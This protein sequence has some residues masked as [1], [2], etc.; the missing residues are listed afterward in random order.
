MQAILATAKKDNPT[1]LTVVFFIV[2][3]LWWLTIYLSGTTDSSVNH[4]FGFIYG[5]FSIWG[6]YWGLKISKEWGGTRSLMGR[7]I[8]GLA[9]GLLFQAFGQY[10]FWFY[11]YILRISVPYPSISDV[12]FFGTIPFYIYAAFLFTKASGGKISLR[13]V[14]KQV[15]AIVIPIIM[16]SISYFLFLRNYSFDSFE[17]LKTFFDFGYPMGQAIYISIAILNYSLCRELLGGIMRNKIILLIIA[18]FAQ[19]LAD[20]IFI[21]FHDLYF[22]ASF[23]DYMYLVAYFLMTLALLQIKT[24]ANRFREGKN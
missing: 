23:I 15:H 19:Y 22:P 7:A 14:A 6:G 17:P 12:G 24:V 4:I 13:S 2:L 16:L 8:I 10:S 9:L 18:F 20:Y 11:N 21:Y 1:I 5:G 3:S